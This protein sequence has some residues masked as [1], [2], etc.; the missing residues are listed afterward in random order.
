MCETAHWRFGRRSRLTSSDGEHKPRMNREMTMTEESI[1][2]ALF[3]ILGLVL[4]G[5]PLVTVGMQ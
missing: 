3:T 4:I 2:I 1:M 5:V